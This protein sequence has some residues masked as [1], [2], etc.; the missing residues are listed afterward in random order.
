M[1][2]YVKLFAFLTRSVSQAVLAQYPDGIRAGTPLE[3]ELPRGSTLDDLTTYLDLPK[4]QIKVMFING[5]AREPDH[6]LGPGDEVGIFPP[7][8]G[9]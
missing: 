7:I 9:G 5:R 4:E 3:V 6:P 2:V 8:A 1:K